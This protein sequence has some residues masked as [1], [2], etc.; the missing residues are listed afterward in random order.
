MKKAPSIQY[1]ITSEKGGRRSP[2][3]VN[4]PRYSRMALLTDS[5]NTSR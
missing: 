2:M 1:A 4:Q 5:L 3:T